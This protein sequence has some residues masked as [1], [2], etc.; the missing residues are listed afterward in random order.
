MMAFCYDD[1]LFESLKEQTQRFQ[2]ALGVVE[3]IHPVT[4]HFCVRLPLCK[5][6]YDPEVVQVYYNAGNRLMLQGF[7][8]HQTVVLLRSLI[9]HYELERCQKLIQDFTNH[10]KLNAI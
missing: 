9:E 10:R 6:F 5:G 1:V 2:E 3:D 8:I 7:S 4:K